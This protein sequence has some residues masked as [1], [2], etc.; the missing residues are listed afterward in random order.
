MSKFS[1]R[2]HS[3]FYPPTS[4]AVGRRFIHRPAARL[5]VR[6]Q[7]LGSGPDQFVVLAESPMTRRRDLILSIVTA[8]CWIILLAII[9]NSIFAASGL[10]KQTR[11]KDR[12]KRSGSLM[13]LETMGGMGGAAS[14]ADRGGYRQGV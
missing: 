8:G 4:R 10:D 11:S 13:I 9:L 1:F 3:T 14:W 7:S 6:C 12:L 5:G 2:C